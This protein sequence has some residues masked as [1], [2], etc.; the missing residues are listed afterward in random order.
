[1]SAAQA[2][3]SAA[4]DDVGKAAAQV[5]IDTCEAIIAASGDK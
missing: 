2:E 4:A 1:M 5:K 3:M